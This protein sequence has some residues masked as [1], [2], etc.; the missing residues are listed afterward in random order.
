M[1]IIHLFCFNYFSLNTIKH[2]DSFWTFNFHLLSSHSKICFFDKWSLNCALG[3]NLLSSPKYKCPLGWIKEKL[4]SNLKS[5]HIILNQQCN[6]TIISM[7]PTAYLAWLHFPDVCYHWVV[8]VS[9][10][11][12]TRG[13]THILKCIGKFVGLLVTKTCGGNVTLSF[14]SKQLL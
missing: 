12:A 1:Q 14:Q 4:H 6:A 13:C 10:L 7:F 3:I 2:L 8:V 11:S 5:T 9:E